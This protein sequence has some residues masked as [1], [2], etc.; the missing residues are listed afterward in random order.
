MNGGFELQYRVREPGAP[1]SITTMTPTSCL[2]RLLRLWILLL[3]AYCLAASAAVMLHSFMIV[4]DRIDISE[5][6]SSYAKQKREIDTALSPEDAEKE[7]KVIEEAKKYGD[8]RAVLTFMELEEKRYAG[9][10]W[11]IDAISSH[12]VQIRDGIESIL[13]FTA[14]A[15]GLVALP[16]IIFLISSV[17][18]WV[19]NVKRSDFFIFKQAMRDSYSDLPNNVRRL[20]QFSSYLL[21]AAGVTL[22]A[23]LISPSKAIAGIVSA[24]A[25]AIILGCL[26][27]LF[28]RMAR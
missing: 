24:V 11:H 16:F 12:S 17:F 4:K 13:F 6:E 2:R 19:W 26:I 18:G 23:F 15:F 7:R 8:S 10:K 1:T 5:L 21:L 25:Q 14:G 9:I 27:W 3:L 28:R 20:L 22:A